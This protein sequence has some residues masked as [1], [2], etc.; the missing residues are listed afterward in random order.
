MRSPFSDGPPDGIEHFHLP[1]PDMTAP[2]REG[3]EKAVDFI[4]RQRGEGRPV[5]VHCGAG[6]G[7]TGT[8]L[9]CYL[10]SEGHDP[11]EAITEVRSARPGSVE[12]MEQEQC[13][14]DYA[15]ARGQADG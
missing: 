14:R 4:R 3:I 6:L 12:T 9:A 8:L 2:P 1:V 11:E 15:A 10:V 7:R 13:I 5:L